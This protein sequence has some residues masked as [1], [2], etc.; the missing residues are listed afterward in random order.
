MRCMYVIPVLA[1]FVSLAGCQTTDSQRTALAAY[2]DE[3]IT[4]SNSAVLHVRGMSCPKCVTNVDLQVLALPGVQE[5]HVDMG[6]GTVRV[7]FDP[8]LTAPR[9]SQAALARAVERAGFT[10]AGIDLD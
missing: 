1:L 5:A 3:A 2:S 4:E 10:L 9:P 7:T 8:D 6:A